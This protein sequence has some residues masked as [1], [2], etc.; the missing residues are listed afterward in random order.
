MDTRPVTEW[1]RSSAG[2]DAAML[3]I[4][5]VYYEPRP[6]EVVIP[7]PERIVGDAGVDA[8][9]PNQRLAGIPVLKQPVATW[10]STRFQRNDFH[11]MG[12]GASAPVLADGAPPKVDTAEAE[13][14]AAEEN[15]AWNK[16]VLN[17]FSVKGTDVL[18]IGS[19]SVV[20]KGVDLSTGQAVAVKNLKA[21]SSSKFRREVFLF[22]ALFMPEE[23]LSK[24]ACKGIERSPTVD[25][26]SHQDLI[27]ACSDAERQKKGH[28]LQ[29]AEQYGRALLH[30]TSALAFLHSRL[31]IHGDMKPANIMWFQLS[32]RWKLI[33][34]DGLRTPAEVV[35]MKDADFYTVIYAAPELA[36]AV[37]DEAP[38]RLSR[39]LDVWSAGLCVLEMKLLRPFLESKFQS[40]CAESADGDGL[41]LFF[42][43]LGSTEE[44]FEVPKCEP[45]EVLKVIMAMLQRDPLE[46]SS[47]A[48]LLQDPVLQQSYDN[49]PDVLLEPLEPAEAPSGPKRKTAYQ[50]F[51]EA[52]R[53]EAKGPPTSTHWGAPTIF[54]FQLLMPRVHTC[55]LILTIVSFKD[56]ICHHLPLFAMICH[57]FALFDLQFS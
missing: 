13:A 54:H 56:S 14:E 23:A 28:C 39:C 16:T 21:S 27:L 48:Q 35:D 11:S 57:H 17:R 34:M 30:V 8:T 38:L 50:L 33:D 18:G 12:C 19:F 51:Q 5:A 26:H 2:E 53:E 49:L 29:N 6:A 41:Q 10:G 43:W 20:R 47:P 24:G 55:S 4:R 7:L 1:C 31:F 36:R 32:K 40:C 37:A 52:H 22:D 45:F 25:L 46:R 15:W 3:S 42:R 9:C 44:P